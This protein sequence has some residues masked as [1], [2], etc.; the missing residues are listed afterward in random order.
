MVG[1][2]FCKSAAAI[3][4]YCT[5]NSTN[6]SYLS[7][8]R[9]AWRK[10]DMFRVPQENYKLVPD[11][12]DDVSSFSQSIEFSLSPP[13]E[14]KTFDKTSFSST[15]TPVP[16]SDP[17]ETARDPELEPRHGLKWYN[18]TGWR[19]GAMCSALL[20]ASSLVLNMV[21]ATWGS[22]KI[23]NGLKHCRSIPRRLQ[24]CPN[25]QYLDTLGY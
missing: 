22:K 17:Q 3:V 20:A 5:I 6:R 23:W 7:V 10:T 13:I 2:I 16:S 24:A 18:V 12:A 9:L 8:L 4:L 19:T 21:V 11:N 25:Y 1:V 14:L 15:F